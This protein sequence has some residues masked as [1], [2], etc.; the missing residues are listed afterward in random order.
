MMKIDVSPAFV[1]IIGDQFVQRL[2][3]SEKL[4]SL[5]IHSRRRQ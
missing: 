3:E 2:N 5:G 4:D 1:M